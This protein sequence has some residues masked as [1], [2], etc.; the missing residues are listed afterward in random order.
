MHHPLFM[1]LAVRLSLLCRRTQYHS[2]LHNTHPRVY[3]FHL[4]V[5]SHDNALTAA[6]SVLVLTAHFHLMVWSFAT[7]RA[8]VPGHVFIVFPD[9]AHDVVESV[10]DVD[11]GF[12]GG[13]DEFATELSG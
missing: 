12:G 5:P 3:R 4:I 1:H 10:V 2:Y 7:A 13:L 6:P 11:A 8:R 9:L